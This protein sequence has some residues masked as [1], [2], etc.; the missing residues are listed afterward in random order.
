MDAY[1]SR[2]TVAACGGTTFAAGLCFLAVLVA[3]PSDNAYIGLWLI[4]CGLI[5]SSVPYA[6]VVALPPGPGA[7]VA[8]VGA[9]VL[10]ALV[11][12]IALLL[13]SQSLLTIRSAD[14]GYDPR[15]PRNHWMGLGVLILTIAVQIAACRPTWKAWRSA[16]LTDTGR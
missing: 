14:Y 8:F 6:V 1:T 4:G 3:N 13:L 10:S 16:R 12:V 15:I 7:R 5:I 11:G 9:L 2:R